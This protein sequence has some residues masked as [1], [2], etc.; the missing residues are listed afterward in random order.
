MRPPIHGSD[1]TGSQCS[2]ELALDSSQWFHWLSHTAFISAIY[3]EGKMTQDSHFCLFLTIYHL[4]ESLLLKNEI[5]IWVWVSFS[6]FIYDCLPA[7]SRIIWTLG[8][9]LIDRF[10]GAYVVRHI[11]M[12]DV[13][14]SFSSCSSSLPCSS[15]SIVI[16]TYTLET[17]KFPGSRKT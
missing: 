10:L 16:I 15:L 8:F 13:H 6:S 11:G 7:E 14:C 12:L 9:Y 2:Q 4:D 3:K 1:L 17:L 5:Q